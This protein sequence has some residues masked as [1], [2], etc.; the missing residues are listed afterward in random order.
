VARALRFRLAVRKSEVNAMSKKLFLIAPIALMV[1]S[2]TASAR[3]PEFRSEFRS[4][5]RP[6]VAFRGPSLPAMAHEL[7]R[8]ARELSVRANHEIFARGRRRA[9]TLATIRQFEIDA[10]RF[11]ALVESRRS[12]VNRSRLALEFDRLERSFDR[13]AWAFERNLRPSYALVQDFRRVETSMSRL[14]ARL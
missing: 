13:T 6:A 8:A 3:E 9:E 11:H 7:D 5:F 4:E 10:R 2:L 1:A 12:H 14:D